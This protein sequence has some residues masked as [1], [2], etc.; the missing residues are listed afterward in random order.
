M[1]ESCNALFIGGEKC[2]DSEIAIYEALQGPRHAPAALFARFQQQRQT[3]RAAARL[4][5]WRALS[6]YR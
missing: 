1:S 5:N 4:F 6:P 3:V 2:A